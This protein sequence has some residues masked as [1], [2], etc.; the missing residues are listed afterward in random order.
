MELARVM[1]KYSYN[2]T[3][4][5]LIIIGEEQGLN[6]S[7]AFA[8]YC[9]QKGI[10]V[11]AVLNND[12]IGG[13][14]C[15]NTA[16]P[17]G[18]SGAGTIDSTHVRL[19]SF[20]GFNS[21]NKGLAR[22][23]KLQYINR[24]KPITKVPMVVNIMT[25]EDRTGRGSDHIPFRQHFYPA[26]RFTAANE[27]GDAG[28]GPT[29]KDRQHTS[30]DILGVDTDSDGKIDSFFVDFN[31]LG[32]NTVMNGCAAGMAAISPNVPD[33]TFAVDGFTNLKV[34]ITQQTQYAKYKVGL[35]TNTN[36]WD[37]VYYFTGTSFSLPA[38]PATYIASVA[39]V[40]SKGVESLFSK[41]LTATVSGIEDFEKPIKAIELLQSIPNPA[42]ES[43]LITVMVSK[44]LDFKLAYI[45][46]SDLSGKE[47]NRI[48]IELSEG[49]NEV[50]YDHGYHQSGTFIYTLVIDGKPMQSRRMVFI[51]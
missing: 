30:S 50:Q 11:K 36:D 5:F 16:S 34:T 1:S 24:I 27:N 19:F 37:S 42:D 26:I 13:V 48:S 15:G 6:G 21:F 25:P 40:D 43:T 47:L 28:V 18:C 41:E 38:G 14:I 51:N 7:E 20:G 29:Y 33:F 23:C 49:I 10:A 12:V 35:R 8:D 32:R 44:H 46:I 17:P 22:Y 45:S 31:Y 2:H 4:V 39:S 9:Q 3:L